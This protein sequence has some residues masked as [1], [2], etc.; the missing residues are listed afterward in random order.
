MSNA[1]IGNSG[2]RLTPPGYLSDLQFASN[3]IVHD[4]SLGDI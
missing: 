4:D 1:V 3:N 2:I